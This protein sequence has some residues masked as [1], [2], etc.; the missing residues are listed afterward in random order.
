[1]VTDISP[2]GGKRMRLSEVSRSA[3]IMMAAAIV[4]LLPAGSYA[5]PVFTYD[6]TGGGFGAG[7]MAQMNTAL[8]IA[9]NELSALFS[10]NAHINIQ[11]QATTATGL[12]DSNFNIGDFPPPYN[13]GGMD[14]ATAK[15]I[16][17]A[18]SALHPENTALASTVANL[19]ATMWA[20]PS[21]DNTRGTPQFILPDAERMA[22]TGVGTGFTYQG[23]IRIN[24]NFSYDADRSP[25]GA[26]QI[27]LV[28]VLEHEITH[29]MGRV[30]YA[31]V[32]NANPFMTFMDM[33]R[34]NCG[35]STHNTV[36]TNACLSLDGGAT[37]L[38]QWSSISDTGDWDGA[39]LSPDNAFIN[40]ATIYGPFG[41]RSY[42]VLNMNALGWDPVASQSAPGPSALVLLVVGLL[43]LGLKRRY[44]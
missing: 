22:L 9:D 29:V 38:R 17:A 10:N 12:A 2:A 13:G 30:N 18:H 23:Y 7:F 6:F 24:P 4:L 43:G 11:Y 31:F 32:G 14:Y 21:C 3:L 41:S 16:T 40:F 44:R 42:D 36:S 5:N 1:M 25:I 39:Q 28:A 19:P 35:T 8:A 20:C 33:D 27:D 26:G 34:F 37:D 15:A